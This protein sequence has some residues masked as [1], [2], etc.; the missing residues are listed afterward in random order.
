MVFER[1]AVPH[2]VLGEGIGSQLIVAVAFLDAVVTK[3]NAPMCRINTHQYKSVCIRRN[4]LLTDLNFPVC[5]SELKIE[6][7]TPAV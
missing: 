4:I 3:V 1:V 6:D 5:T 7:S 2:V